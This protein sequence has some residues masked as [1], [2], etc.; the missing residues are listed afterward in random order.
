MKVA[1]KNHRK[2]NFYLIHQDNQLLRNSH[3]ISQPSINIF[4]GME[5]VDNY[6]P[7]CPADNPFKTIKK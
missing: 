4:E 7:T 6:F 3:N 1:V 2:R 5:P